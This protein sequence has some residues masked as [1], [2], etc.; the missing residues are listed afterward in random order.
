VT[1]DVLEQALRLWGDPV[2][3]GGAALAAFG[4]VYTDPL[5][6]NGVLMPLS[7]VVERAR[8]LQGAPRAVQLSGP[9]SAV[10]ASV[11]AVADAITERTAES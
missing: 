1:N 11:A 7:E 9:A 10:E 5:R 6:V 8:R 2:P 4:T 3:D